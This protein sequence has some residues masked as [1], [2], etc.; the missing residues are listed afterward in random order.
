MRALSEKLKSAL[1]VLA[2]FRGPK[3]LHAVRFGD[4][5]PVNRK[6]NQVHDSTVRLTDDTQAVVDAVGDGTAPGTLLYDVNKALEDA[7][8]A[9]QAAAEVHQTA[10]QISDDL[11][12]LV[13]GYGGS[14]TDLSQHIGA[15]ETTITLQQ[16]D[17]AAA[18]AS[19]EQANA[20]IIRALLRLSELETQTRQA[21]LY[22][23]EESGTARIEALERLAGS[24]N[25]VS[26][27]LDAATAQIALRATR[28]EVNQVVSEALLD[29]TQVPIVNEL[30]ARVSSVELNLD[31]IENE[32]NAKASATVVNGYGVRIGTAEQNISGLQAAIEQK[33]S[34]TDFD[35]AETRITT[36]EQSL[37][38]I[39]GASFSQSLWDIRQA[40]D[41]ADA[42]SASNL[43]QLL[44][45]YQT[46]EALKVDFAYATEDLRV[47]VRDN[48][49]AIST[50]K[51]ELGAAIDGNAA[52]ILTEQKARVSENAALAKEVSEFKASFDGFEAYA[53]QSFYV[54]SDADQAIAQ[55][56]TDLVAAL[57]SPG[58]SIGSLEANLSQNYLSKVDT[59]SAITAAKEEMRGEITQLSGAAGGFSV[60]LDDLA[61]LHLKPSAV[62]SNTPQFGQDNTI[63]VTQT[64]TSA[65]TNG[66]T[67]GGAVIEIPEA[68]AQRYGARRVK[69]SVLARQP[70]NY[71][72]ASF[73]VAYST[74]DTGGSGRLSNAPAGGTGP[75]WDWFHF[76]YDVPA[77]VNGGP[78]YLGL[79]GDDSG[80]S[81]K[82]EF[83]KVAIQVAAEAED[84]PEIAQISGELN[85]VKV[86]DLTAG[87]AFASMLNQMGVSANG[88]VAGIENF[89]SA[90]ADIHG[91]AQAAY[92]LR[93]KAGGQQGE[94]EIVA[95][96]N[97]QGAGSAIILTSDN[98]FAKGLLQADKFAVGVA[99]NMLANADLEMGM[100][101]YTDGGTGTI[102]SNREVSLLAP[103]TPYAG[104]DYSTI[105]I[106]ANTGATTSGYA[107][108][109]LAP[110]DADGNRKLGYRV[111]KE[112]WYE[113]HCAVSATRANFKLLVRWYDGQGNIIDTEEMLTVNGAPAGSSDN[114]E[115][116]ERYGALIKSPDKAAF[117][118]PMIQLH[119]VTSGASG[120]IRVCNPFFAKTVEGAKLSN[121]GTGN[122]TLVTGDGIATKGVKAKHI[123]VIELAALAANI[124]HFKSANSG[125][126]V[127]IKDDEIRI[128][129]DNDQ[130]AVALG[131]IGDLVP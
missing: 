125:E 105:E 35:Q 15:I 10:S 54:K 108:L 81:K 48:R 120:I 22:V 13:D 63:I 8:Q 85:D 93:A 124:G 5:T 75:G 27:A 66:K 98:I 62:L 106:K 80:N 47:L 37:A 126:R 21:G 94:M 83:A 72:A 14:L 76:Y 42:A 129:Y 73:S 92:V 68:V 70:A 103:N 49:V 116:W 12:A 51:S 4:L 60:T 6:L 9:G 78:D 38:A 91:N 123:D 102:G 36:A 7:R 65:S 18:A 90:M 24:L 61:V 122:V 82:T 11:E 113:W 16:P 40:Q 44:E 41:A 86:L 130:V 32:L 3:H 64:G 96:D 34:Q 20:S 100:L 30:T 77:P 127:E 109:H 71:P 26:I 50:A 19:A 107:R 29:P 57:E 55:A 39:D 31:G 58:G 101:H 45:L 111:K 84:L 53:R 67:S 46:R 1:E 115:E 33:V 56:G 99:Q 114:P 128:Y 89:G 131:Y 95:W 121:Y 43:A 117:A 69:I 17:I 74:N 104:Y 88:R 25:E 52:Q 28:T 59:Q 110:E 87:T 119:E 23:D 97:A 112:K 79:F 2:G 118:R